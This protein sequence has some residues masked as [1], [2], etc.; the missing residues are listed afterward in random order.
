M[1]TLLARTIAAIALVAV[2]PLFWFFIVWIKLTDGGSPF[3]VQERMGKGGKRFLCYKFRTMHIDAE[4]TLANWK[5]M[6]SEEWQQY[7]EGNFKLKDDPRV[8]P[9]GKIL[10]KTSLDELPQL[11]NI[12][13]GDM[14]WVGPRPLLEQEIETYGITNFNAYCSVLP[15]L[16]G[17]WQVSGRSDTGF[18]QRIA[19]DLEYIRNQSIK[20]DL[21]IILK[22]IK[23]VLI[24]KGSY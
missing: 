19:K 14:A 17:L 21:T 9:V 2:T 4:K 20:L 22:T 16:T 24:G 15:G 12:I 18:D 13:S 6:N 5:Q 11:F 7:I 10:R 23:V 3:F 1:S 8:T